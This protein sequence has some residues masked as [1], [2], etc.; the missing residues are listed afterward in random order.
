MR[1]FELSEGTSHKFWQVERAGTSMNVRF[2]RIG[3]EGQSQT[4]S[5][6]SESAAQAEV[7]KLI[8]E[9]VK[10]GYA[11]VG[12]PA[13]SAAPVAAPAAKAAAPKPA[14]AAAPAVPSP[15]PVEAPAAAVVAVPPVAKSA[16]SRRGSVAWTEAAL[17]AVAPIRGSDRFVAKKPDGTALYAKLAKVVKGL[18][19]RFEAGAKLSEARSHVELMAAARREF[20]GGS[21]PERLDLDAQAAMYAMIAPEVSWD[22]APNGDDLVAFWH[23]CEGGIFAIRARAKAATLAARATRDVIALVDGTPHKRV[24]WRKQMPDWSAF[25]NVAAGAPPAEHAELV[26]E[27]EALLPSA[28]PELRAL[29][30]CAFE[31]PEWAEADLASLG[32]NAP[33]AWVWP[34]L[35][36]L[37]STAAVHAAFAKLRGPQHRYYVLRAINEIRFDL[38]ARYGVEIASDLVELIGRDAAGSADSLR[39]GAAAL[40]LIVTDEVASFF[41]PHLATKELRAIAAEYLQAHPEVSVVPLATAAAAGKGALAEAA[42]A[43]LKSV[44]ASGH[45]AV[46]LARAALPPAAARVIDELAEKAEAREDAAPE[47]LP[48]VLRDPPWIKRVAAQAPL[49]LSLERLPFE[50]TMAWRPGETAARAVKMP[51]IT[52]HPER[53]AH[54]VQEV[55]ATAVTPPAHDL[56]SWKRIAASRLALLPKESLREILPTAT[57]QHFSGSFAEPARGIVA[58]DGLEG[59][60][61]ALRVGEVD[62]AS[63]VEALDHANAA[64]VAPLMANAFVNLKKVKPTA[65]GWLQAF[66]EAAA[67]GLIPQALGPLGKDRQAAEMALRFVASKGHRAVVEAVAERYGAEAAKGV[68]AVL[69][70]DPL[71]VLPAK[72]PKLPAFWSAGAFTRPLLAGGQRAVPLEAVEAIGTML[73]FSPLDDPYAG[74]LELKAACDRRSLGD[75]AWD[76]FQAWLVSGAPAKESWAF[77]A[78]GQIGDDEC[79]RKLTPLVRAWPG[80]AAHARAVTGLDVLAGIGSDVALMHLHG[81]AQKLKFKGL[82]ERAREKIDQI[83]EVRGLTADEL[84]DRLVP[85]LSLDEDGSASLDFGPRRFRVT[86]DETLKPLVL[87]EAGKRLPDLPK[88]KQSDDE[89]KSKEAVERWKALKKDAKTLAS[90][91]I[92]RLEI[93]M[94]SQRRWATEVFRRFLVEHPVVIH[95]VRRLVWGVYGEDGLVSSFRVAEDRSFADASDGPFDLREGAEIGVVHRLDLSDAD[96]AAW[97]QVFGDYEI[98]QPFEQLSR[99]VVA[100]TE[101]QRAASELDVAVGIEVPTGKVLGLDARG[102]RRGPTQDAGVVGW[103]EKPVGGGLVA[104]MDLEPGIFTG[105]ISESPSQKLGKVTLANGSRAYWGGGTRVPFSG[106]PRIAFSEL[107]RDLSSLRA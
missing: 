39:T 2:G 93:A 23:A 69:D 56:P 54:A 91:Q 46:P 28:Q 45:E 6:A 17:R 18:A 83:A 19:P 38:L 29:F 76:L 7:D 104:C 43:V 60:A 11:E 90:G 92:L 89:E 72:V 103:Y 49:M 22:D 4:K 20:A 58:R 85:D 59:I 73:A 68:R 102:W 95:L 79:A 86:F 107:L 70:F 57:L 106:L 100:P 53:L 51:W 3:T 26:A 1:R 62:G 67:V 24:Y 47:D 37:G 14:K 10:K 74:V 30:A 94:C 88:A 97:G 27:V 77:T 87:D 99:A 75:F 63:A 82:Q 65:V 13:A 81:I 35:V 15:E 41:T 55:L 52:D 8:K 105:V 40:A 64:R 101:A 66:P 32:I 5:F 84:A 96:A 44:V 21:A 42:R 71:L 61:F 31:R 25:R 16:A 50:E 33:E 36:S 48:R 12:A 78:M 9:K 80:E 34:L 98:L